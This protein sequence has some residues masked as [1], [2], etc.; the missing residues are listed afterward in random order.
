MGSAYFLI[1]SKFAMICCHFIVCLIIMQSREGNVLASI[2]DN[3]DTNSEAYLF[4]DYQ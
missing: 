2:G 4:A 3:T 1:P